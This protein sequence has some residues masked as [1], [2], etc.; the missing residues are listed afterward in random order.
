MKNYIL[1]L[2]VCLFAMA[3]NAQIIKDN[4]PRLVCS[5]ALPL[6]QI[7]GPQVVLDPLLVYQVCIDPN[8][9]DDKNP[10]VAKHLVGLVKV[11]NNSKR[12]YTLMVYYFW[13]G[14]QV[15]TK[16]VSIQPNGSQLYQFN[17]RAKPK[18]ENENIS[19]EVRCEVRKLRF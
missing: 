8:A 2:S 12:V 17:L 10:A 3:A 19:V 6:Q 9:S 7:G 15:N 18:K 4:F 11:S 1:C 13:K 16:V 5:K 14:N